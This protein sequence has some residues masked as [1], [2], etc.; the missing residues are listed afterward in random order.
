MCSAVDIKGR[1]QSW[2]SSAMWELE[3][4]PGPRVRSWGGLWKEQLRQP[5]GDTLRAPCEESCLGRQLAA[6]VSC[7]VNEGPRPESLLVTCGERAL[8][9]TVGVAGTDA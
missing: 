4:N 8:T 7:L 2:A 5:H 6:G 3:L 1:K 9:L